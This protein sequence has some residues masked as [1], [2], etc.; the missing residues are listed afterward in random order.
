[1]LEYLIQEI[2]QLDQLKV[3]SVMTGRCHGTPVLTLAVIP[4]TAA[5]AAEGVLAVA[6]ATEENIVPGE[7]EVGGYLNRFSKLVRLEEMTG[8]QPIDVMVADQDADWILDHW[9]R[10]YFFA[11]RSERLRNKF[12][13]QAGFTC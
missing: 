7:D 3:L 9:P 8:L 13:D 1:M 2:G 11:P 10:L 5:S 6:D 12:L 4:A